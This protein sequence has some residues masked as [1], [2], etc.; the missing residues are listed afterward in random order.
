MHIELCR[1]L[2]HI[3]ALKNIAAE[4]LAIIGG[5]LLIKVN[6]PLEFRHDEAL[7]KNTVAAMLQDYFREVIKEIVDAVFAAVIYAVFQCQTSLL[8]IRITLLQIVKN[9][10]CPT[11]EYCLL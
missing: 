3:T 2:C 4:R 5:I 8:D 6:K 9:S 7:G 11:G 10:A 1:G